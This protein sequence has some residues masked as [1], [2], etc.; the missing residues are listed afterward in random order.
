VPVLMDHGLIG[1]IGK[2]ERN[3][4]VC[5]AIEQHQ[6]VYFCAVGGAGALAAKCIR[7]CTVVAFED[8]GCESVKRFELEKFPLVVA[9]DCHGGNLFVSG[10]EKYAVN[11]ITT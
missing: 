11:D 3:E 7:K 6:G 4:T 2:G 9:T 1:M 10:R 8:L 5:R